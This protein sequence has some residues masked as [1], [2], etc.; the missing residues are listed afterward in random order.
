MKNIKKLIINFKNLIKDC[1]LFTIYSIVNWICV[2]LLT[3]Y[4]SLII[5]QYISKII[6][7]YNKNIDYM[8]FN[9]ILDIIW[10]KIYISFTFANVT[11]IILAIYYI[12]IYSIPIIS[13]F[14]SKIIKQFFFINIILFNIILFNYIKLIKIILNISQNFVSTQTD[15]FFIMEISLTNFIEIFCYY[16]LI[17]TSI[18]L[19]SLGGNILLIISNKYTYIIKPITILLI[20][21]IILLIAP[22]DIIIQLNILLNFLIIFE[23]SQIYIKIYL[24][25]YK[26]KKIIN[27]RYRT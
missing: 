12:Y 2:F 27:T 18:F 22:P 19:I 21:L 26:F 25:Y 10:L 7:N 3:F 15:F 13:K 8:I 4:K 5:L 23:I 1:K 14:L 20:I 6:K 11:T 24:K 16:I 9:N 17:L